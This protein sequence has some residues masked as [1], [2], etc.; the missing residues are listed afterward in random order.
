MAET[1]GAFRIQELDG[2]KRFITLVGRALPY[3]DAGFS[4]P[5]EQRANVTWIPGS[6]VGTLTLL[7]GK[8]T[9][10]TISGMWKQKYLSPGGEDSSPIEVDGT[11]VR[12]VHEV[13]DLFEKICLYGTRLDV[14][15]M[16]VARV[17]IIR[18][19]EPIWK[20][21]LDVE[22]SIS[23]EWI[24]RGQEAGALI[25]STAESVSDIA[26][27]T[28]AKF[29]LFDLIKLP[30]NFALFD[31]FVRNL[32]DTVNAIQDF[33]LDLENY[34]Q[35]LVRKVTYPAQALRGLVTIVQN[36][37]TEVGLLID[38][39]IGR[40]SLA[41]IGT[42]ANV[43]VSAAMSVDGAASVTPAQKLEAE[44]FKR[45]L[46]DWAAELKRVADEYNDSLSK[47]L[48]GDVDSTYQAVQGDTLQLVSQRFYNTPHEWRRLMTYNG[49][50]SAVLAAGQVVFI[51]KLSSASAGGGV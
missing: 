17:G 51:P 41:I 33:I 46:V 27:V 12:N 29:D 25:S 35:N 15:W 13:V 38:D 37:G 28:K 1:G 21:H 3:R 5:V 31:E 44:R 36:I 4:A 48:E 10:T 18:K 9:S 14:T 20:T 50:E 39:I 24:S 7:G 43:S 26:S 6:P 19:F 16:S 30:I 40:T 47:Q 22:W 42:Q 23:F 49:F 8:E 45:E 32:V 34:V 2:D 11:P